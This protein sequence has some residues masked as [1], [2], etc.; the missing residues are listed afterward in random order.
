VKRTVI[1]PS[2]TVPKQK[3]R[4]SAPHA[5]RIEESRL[6]YAERNAVLDAVD[7]ILGIVPFE[8]RRAR[9]EYV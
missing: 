3:Y 7:V 5:L 2:A 1:T 6:R 8:N 9:Y 4:G